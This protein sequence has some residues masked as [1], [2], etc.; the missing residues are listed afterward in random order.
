MRS[1]EGTGLSSRT[2]SFLLQG[3]GGNGLKF[4]RSFFDN[5]TCP[6]R[7]SKRTCVCRP[8]CGN[9]PD[10]SQTLLTVNETAWLAYVWPLLFG[11][12]RESH[13]SQSV[14]IK[15]LYEELYLPAWTWDPLS[16]C[17]KEQIL[18]KLEISSLLGKYF[19]SSSSTQFIEC[20][21]QVIKIQIQTSSS[22][23]STTAAEEEVWPG[24]G[25]TVPVVAA[26]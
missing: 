25:A 6:A 24:K 13:V 21:I 7:A 19:I 8:R 20:V 4:Q 18:L 15:L 1:A 22:P 14:R 17:P 5:V 9:A 3:K 16:S 2:K 12:C 26:G 23:W 11:R 10:C